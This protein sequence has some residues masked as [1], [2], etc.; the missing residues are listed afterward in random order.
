MKIEIFHSVVTEFKNIVSHNLKVYT[1]STTTNEKQF[2]NYPKS[3]T[4]LR[5]KLF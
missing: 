2:L 1:D 4:K 3:W 5:K